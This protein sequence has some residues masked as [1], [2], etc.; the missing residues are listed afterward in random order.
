MNWALNSPFSICWLVPWS[1]L[2]PLPCLPSHDGQAFQ[3]TV[4][5]N[6][7]NL[8]FLSLFLEHRKVTKHGSLRLVSW[9]LGNW[10]ANLT[11]A[12]ERKYNPQTRIYVWLGKVSNAQEE[13]TRWMRASL[14]FL[15]LQLCSSSLI[16][17]TPLYCPQ[18]VWQP[19]AWAL[20]TYS[21]S[22]LNTP[23][24]YDWHLRNLMLSAYFQL[25]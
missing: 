1:N 4:S 6:K 9:G 18:M 15:L 24:D 5:Y 7:I 3:W 14:H 20:C 13:K 2:F 17:T 11:T 22:W 23:V 16:T 12:R 19:Q 8:S 25:S 10:K 21:T